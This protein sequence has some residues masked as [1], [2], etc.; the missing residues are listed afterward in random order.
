MNYHNLLKPTIYITILLFGLLSVFKVQSAKNPD[1]QRESIEAT[2]TNETT[3]SEL[4]SIK[5]YLNEHDIKLKIHKV[6]YDEDNTIK[7]LSCGVNFDGCGNS[8]FSSMGSFKRLKIYWR[9][10]GEEE[11]GVT[12][13]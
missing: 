10:E 4:D 5:N 6:E 2:I 8:Q 11:C 12:G 13:G 7:S 9:F 1:S 3:E